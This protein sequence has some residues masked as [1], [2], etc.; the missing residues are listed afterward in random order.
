MQTLRTRPFLL[1]LILLLFLTLLSGAVYAISRSLGYIPGVGIVDQ[2]IPLRVIAEP[3]I[4]EQD[5]TR[6]VV[7]QAVSSAHETMILYK[8]NNIKS[9]IEEC[10]ERPHLKLSD[11]TL[12][13]GMLI[14]I[15]S[16]N[17]KFEGDSKFS[18]VPQ[19]VNEAILLFDCTQ[20]SWEIPL[21]F[22]QA[23]LDM[24][25]PIRELSTSSATSPNALVVEKVIETQNSYILLGR[26]YSIGFPEGVIAVSESLWNTAIIT[27]AK[28]RKISFTNPNGIE[29][30]GEPGNFPW[31]FEIPG[32]EHPWPLTIT[33]KQ[34]RVLITNAQADFM[35]DAGSNPQ[36]GQK[37]DVDHDIAIAEYSLHLDYVLHTGTGYRLKFADN[38]VVA[39][40]MMEIV[41]AEN[42]GSPSLRGGGGNGSDGLTCRIDFEEEVPSG[43]M[44]IRLFHLEINIDGT[45]QLQWKPDRLP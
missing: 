6:I 15:G 23:P 35:F 12:L 26:F 45:W 22:V 19:S 25:A 4:V 40:M 43:K 20:E 31:A 41:D 13:D 11:G 1:A 44:T 39:S 36:G 9:G 16:S 30:T 37:W 33:F 5:G 21:H 29:L 42:P 2:S 3:V 38:P 8:V 32:K 10:W 24:I 7:T 28:G 18:P 34:V 27:D 17:T 14:G